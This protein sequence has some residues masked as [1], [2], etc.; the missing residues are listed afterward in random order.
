MLIH[1]PKASDKELIR[2]KLGVG[3]LYE[4]AV[5]EGLASGA[6]KKVRVSG[7]PMEGNSYMVFHNQRALSA[8]AEVFLSLLRQWRDG[9]SDAKRIRTLP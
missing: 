8:G 6:F 3:F 7:L 2:K 9:E 4:D 1:D 5:K